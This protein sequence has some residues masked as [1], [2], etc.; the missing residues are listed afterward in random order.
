MNVDLSLGM[1]PQTI[2]A[3]G[4]NYFWYVDRN[5]SVNAGGHIDT[6]KDTN[7]VIYLRSFMLFLMVITFSYIHIDTY[8][9]SAQQINVLAF[10]SR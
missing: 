10:L 2:L 3:F 9:V 1:L 4:H 7:D 6:A 5:L 8:L